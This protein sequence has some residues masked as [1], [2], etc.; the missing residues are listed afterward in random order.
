MVPQKRKR[1]GP[2]IVAIQRDSTAGHI[3]KPGNQRR[4]GGL[5]NAGSPGKSDAL[6]AFDGER[7]VLQ[8]IVRCAGVR[9]RHVI[10]T[11]GSG[12]RSRAY[13]MR[14]F[15]YRRRAF[16][17][18]HKPDKACFPFFEQVHKGNQGVNRFR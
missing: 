10:K 12:D 6:A 9:K 16:H 14:G 8:H 18:L 7:Y 1:Q 15:G 13:G 5:S 4:D 2:Y 17:H 11:N 3:V